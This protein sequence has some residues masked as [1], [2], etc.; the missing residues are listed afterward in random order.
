LF[1][2]VFLDATS[3]S[4]H[5]NW[6]LVV[7][8][9]GDPE[10]VAALKRLAHER[11]ARERILFSGW[12]GGLDK[13]AALQGAAMLAL[14]SHQ[15]NFGLVVAEALTC[16]VPVLVS[17]HVNLAQEIE[18]AG[19]GWVAPLERSALLAALL[20]ALQSGDERSRRG[21]RGGDFARAHFKWPAVASE[22]VELYRTVESK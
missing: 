14:P 15:E 17:K 5:C 22:L 11:G 19:A 4:P 21:A 10:Y 8:G 12:L 7:A 6:H 1:L 18:A 16:G 9:D 2:D 13:V 3:A 20:E